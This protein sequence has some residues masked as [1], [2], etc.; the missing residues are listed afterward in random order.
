MPEEIRLVRHGKT[1]DIYELATNGRT[2]RD[3]LLMVVTD[4]LSAFDQRLGATVPGK[5]YVLAALTQFWGARFRSLVT[6]DIIGW[7]STELPAA[8]RSLAGRAML[9]RRLN[10]IRLE[11][12][13]RGYLYGSAL[14]EYAITGSV[15]G[16]HLPR[17]LTKAG[18]LPE[19]IFTPSV[20]NDRKP[21]RNVTYQD[22][23]RLV[24]PAR[25]EK[26]RDVSLR[27][28]ESAAEY[29]EGR[30]L[31]LADTK[32]EFG[33]VD[34][35]I[36]VGDELFTPD[37]SRIWPLATWRPGQDPPSLDRQPLKAWLVANEGRVGERVPD[38]IIQQLSTS[39][40]RAFEIITGERIER[41][42][43]RAREG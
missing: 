5:G 2:R 40:Q 11:C 41:W 19:P 39:Y 25:L 35:E 6:T 33:Y 38:R 4:R 32:L 36:V 13:V 1:R 14:T 23:E 15:C 37:S 31:I 42:L 22:A 26:I 30:G 18:R 12:I 10:M 28:Y 3:V 24:G 21:D 43:E 16:I 17:R 27:M 7:R 20:K 34:S 8:A 9:V 29:M